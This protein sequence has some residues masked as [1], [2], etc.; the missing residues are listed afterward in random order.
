MDDPA[1]STTEELVMR[2]TWRSTSR[3]PS[4]QSSTDGEAISFVDVARDLLGRDDLVH[5]QNL[6]G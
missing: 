6:H 1:S 2:A 4:P 5:V 3:I